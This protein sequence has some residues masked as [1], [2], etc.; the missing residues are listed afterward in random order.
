[1]WPVKSSFI[2]VKNDRYYWRA[3]CPEQ[4]R[5]RSAQTS[6]LLPASPDGARLTSVC[7]SGQLT[8]SHLLHQQ[9]RGSKAASRYSRGKANADIIDHSHFCKQPNNTSHFDVLTQ[10]NKDIIVQLN[11]RLHLHWLTSRDSLDCLY[12][13]TSPTTEDR[14]AVLGIPQRCG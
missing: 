14:R 6:S 11:Q 4:Q 3:F 5:K 13:S 7:A 10:W 9:V 12:T 1:M 2:T 8:A